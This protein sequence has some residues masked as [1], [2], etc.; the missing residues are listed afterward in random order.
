M[1]FQRSCKFATLL[2]DKWE[3]LASLLAIMRSLPHALPACTLLLATSFAAPFAH[4]QMTGC[5][6]QTG[7]TRTHVVELFTS[8]GCSSC[9]PADAWVSSLKGIPNVV[10]LA[11]HVDYW[12]YIGW[13][14]VF[15]NPAYTQRQRQWQARTASRAIYTPQVLLN[16]E[17][18]RRWPGPL[19]SAGKTPSLAPA[20][21][22][23]QSGATVQAQLTPNP[24][25]TTPAALLQGYWAVL[26]DG[27]RNVVKAG[28]NDGRTLLHDHVVVHYLPLAA[29]SATAAQTYTLSLPPPRKGAQSQRV[30]LVVE[31]AQRG[32]PIQALV[33]AC[34]Q[35]R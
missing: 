24:E 13:K 35:G 5:K 16:G 26:E 29:W 2:S 17:A 7:N 12:D 27:H 4:A 32:E 33:L 15:A 3:P 11:F 31:D 18:W 21:A 10:A 22:L 23:S 6:A 8:E 14:D 34:G 30:A 20:L 1:L 25:A 28:E 9:P 19:P